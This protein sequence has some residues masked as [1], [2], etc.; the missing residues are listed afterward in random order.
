MDQRFSAKIYKN[1]INSYVDVPKNV[2]EAFA[3]RGPIPIKGH[4]DSHPICA[5]LVPVGGGRHRLYINSEMRKA[6]GVD[7]GDTIK[8][9]LGFDKESREIPVPSDLALA[10]KKNRGAQAAFEKTISSGCKEI[11]GWIVDAKRPETRERRI[12]SAIDHLLGR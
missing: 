11:L 8:L 4:L 1:G 5:T 3:K 10:L 12:T 2:S 9:R 7:V 6:A